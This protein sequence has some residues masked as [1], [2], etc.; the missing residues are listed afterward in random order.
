MACERSVIYRR[1]HEAQ[2]SHI[3][4]FLR[5]GDV[6]PLFFILARTSLVLHSYLI[7]I[8]G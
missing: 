2:V 7:A 6:I 3:P 5:G 8:S 4:L 1:L